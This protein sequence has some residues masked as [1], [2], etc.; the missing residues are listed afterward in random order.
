MSIA[1]ISSS[2][3]SNDASGNSL[4][5]A[6]LSVTTGNSIIVIVHRWGGTGTPNGVTD[7][8]GN[9][10]AKCGSD[11]SSGSDLVAYYI[12]HNVTGHAN[13]VVTASWSANA[14]YRR[15]I[16]LQ[17][18][19]M[20]LTAAHD[21]GYNPAVASDTTSPLTTTSA[22][23]AENNEMVIGCFVDQDDVDTTFSNS[24]PS[25]YRTSAGNDCGIA[26]NAIA[27][28]GAGTVSVATNQSHTYA[29]YAKAFKQAGGSTYNDS[30][31]ES[32][33][34]SDTG[35]AAAIFGAAIA[36]SNNIADT[37]NSIAILLGSIA[38][39]GA[40]SDVIN[41]LA[42]LLASISESSAISDSLANTAI[43]LNAIAES[44]SI[45][46]TQ[47]AVQNFVD[48]I[49]ES[50]NVSDSITS[51][52]NLICAITDNRYATR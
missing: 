9:T 23:T 25:V 38:E 32:N 48:S 18:S 20:H 40:I 11:M 36:E 10:Y 14:T 4:A 27:S 7:T 5:S 44:N 42:V 22:N 13:N 15:V 3:G 1:F 29:C 6:A 46:D 47:T 26:D 43:F 24:S 28:A 49:S 12:A 45:T 16:Q 37:D 35:T 52:A 33:S 34:I 51:I 39:S 21:T 2:V 41:G 17:Y 30:I 31:A 8:A 50:L 19:G